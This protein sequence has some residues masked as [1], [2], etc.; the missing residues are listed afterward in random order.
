[1]STTRQITII[2]PSTTL[3]VPTAWDCGCNIADGRCARHTQM[4][5]QIRAFWDQPM[6]A[7]VSNAER[8]T[9]NQRFEQ[10]WSLSD[11][12]GTPGFMPA[13]GYDWS[14]IRDSS[15]E[16][17]E[18]MHERLVTLCVGCAN[19]DEETRVGNDGLP[20]CFG[21]AAPPETVLPQGCSDTSTAQDEPPTEPRSVLVHVVSFSPSDDQAGVG[22]FDWNYD[23]EWSLATLQTYLQ[24]GTQRTHNLSLVHVHVPAGLDNDQITAFIDARLGKIEP[25]AWLPDAAYG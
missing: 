1:M 13:Q 10:I 8:R 17:V 12:Y 15:P 7:P 16:A 18:R 21:C 9:W 24:D 25:S 23:L 3:S 11:G 14:G 5:R 22:G 4:M 2:V 6:T 20:R 19:P